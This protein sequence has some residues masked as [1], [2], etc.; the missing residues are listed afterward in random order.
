MINILTFGRS[1]HG[2]NFRAEHSEDAIGR[3]ETEDRRMD[4]YEDETKKELAPVGP[5]SPYLPV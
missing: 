4:G 5:S 1:I 2:C 3:K